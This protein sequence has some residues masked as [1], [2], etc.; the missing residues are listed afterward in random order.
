MNTENVLQVSVSSFIVSA[1]VGVSLQ[2]WQ[3]GSASG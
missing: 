2:T 3:A 1:A